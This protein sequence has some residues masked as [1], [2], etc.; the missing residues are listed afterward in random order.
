MKQ[1]FDGA[2]RQ[3]FDGEERQKF[4]GAERQKQE[5]EL[6]YR[7]GFT[8]YMI[9]LLLPRLSEVA[10]L[11]PEQR[12]V[13]C[14]RMRRMLEQIEEAAREREEEEHYRRLDCRI[15]ECQAARQQAAW[16]AEKGKVI[17]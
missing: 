17:R 5:M 15:R 14:V 7:D 9:Q 1:E 16:K 3:K 2:E 8:Q 13:M 10:A 4:D 11:E 6:L 12:R